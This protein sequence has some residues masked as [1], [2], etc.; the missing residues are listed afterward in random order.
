MSQANPPWPTPEPGPP[1]V[2][3]V[4]PVHDGERFL[5]DTLDSLA[6]WLAGT[7]LSHEILVVDDGS[8]DGTAAAVELARAR[9]PVIRLLRH[10][11]NQGKGAAVRD[12]LLAARGRV[13]LFTDADLAYPVESLA[14]VLDALRA[15]APIVVADREHPASECR[16]QSGRPVGRAG[17]SLLGRLFR[18]LTW[19]LRLSDAGDTQAGLKG[20]SAEAAERLFAVQHVPGFAFDVEVLYQARRAGLP[21]LRVPVVSFHQRGRG[22]PRVLRDSLGMLR[23]LLRLR[24]RAA[25]GG[26]DVAQRAGESGVGRPPL[27]DGARRWCGARGAGAWLAVLAAVLLRFHPLLSLDATFAHHDWMQVHQT[28]AEHVSLAA[29]AASLVPLW[30][31]FLLGGSPLYAVATKPLSYPPFLLAVPLLGAAGA[32]DVLALLHVLLAAAGMLRL[33]RRLDCGPAA[34]AAAAIVFVTGTWPGSLFTSQPFWAYALAWW[35]W[36]LGAALDVLDAPDRRA[37]LSGAVRLGLFMALQ[38]LAGGVFQAYW[39]A[40][41]LA[42]FALPFLLRRGDVAGGSRRFGAL[43][44]AAAVCLAVSAVRVLPALEWMRG[45]GRSAALADEDILSG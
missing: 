41:F 4:V 8:R 23:D 29:R 40:C 19:G 33:A 28:D 32:L 31:P 22:V 5:G 35:P 34:G 25:R 10:P 15:G 3:L 37:L 2:S 14:V 9:H 43:L 13:R 24:W 20:F 39:L 42:V 36:A 45:S 30:S 18:G 27:A 38:V 44:L 1:E 26:Y 11:T 7:R 17:R 16:L 12:G 6:G 21:V